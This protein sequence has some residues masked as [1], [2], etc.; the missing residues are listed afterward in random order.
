[1]LSKVDIEEFKKNWYTF[2]QIQSISNSVDAIDRWELISE[3]QF[4][5]NVYDKINSKMKENV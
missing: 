5:K 4:W 2:E 3:E 1:M